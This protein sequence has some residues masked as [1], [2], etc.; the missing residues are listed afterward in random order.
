MPH[1][2]QHGL[3]KNSFRVIEYSS[4]KVC[5]NVFNFL[6]YLGCFH[7]PIRINSTAV[8]NSV[9]VDYCCVTKHPKVVSNPAAVHSLDVIDNIPKIYNTLNSGVLFLK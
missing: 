9:S 2:G 1:S 6:H 5:Y 3:H 8:T 7:F 4:E